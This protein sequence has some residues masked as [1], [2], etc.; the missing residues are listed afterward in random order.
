MSNAVYTSNGN[1]IDYDKLREKWKDGTGTVMVH[2]APTNSQQFL[3]RIE[4]IPVD[5]PSLVNR[6][7]LEKNLE[8]ILQS[9]N[10]FD[11]RIWNPP[12]VARI[13]STGEMFIYDGDHSRHL[14]R[15]YHHTEETMPAKIVDV[16]RKE[17]VHNLFV[18]ANCKGR[19]AI[20]AEQIFVHTYLGGCPVAKQLAESLQ[21]TGLKVYC[22]A[23][24]GGTAGDPSGYLTKVNGFKRVHKLV[25][26]PKIGLQSHCTAMSTMKAAVQIVGDM[27]SRYSTWS[28]K[29]NMPAEFL[30]AVAYLFATYPSLMPPAGG[31]HSVFE[32]YLKN[33]LA[34]ADKWKDAVIRLKELGGNTVNY[35]ELSIAKGMLK[36]LNNGAGKPGFMKSRLSDKR[37]V[38]VSLSTNK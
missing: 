33:V 36:E 2:P 16:E 26:H 34:N 18:Q 25:N 4:D 21:L 32:S 8:K 29:D 9:M 23:E 1:E 22:S 37:F 28:R 35:P 3:A 27:L 11:G 19:T 5:T 30:G 13:T 14:Y 12:R 20:N 24:I 17:D 31:S 38:E 6:D 15:W 10:G 7:T